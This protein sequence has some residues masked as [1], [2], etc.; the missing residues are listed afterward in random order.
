MMTPEVLT[1]IK[2][3]NTQSFFACENE[4]VQ[5]DDDHS[6]ISVGFSTPTPWKTPREI[7][8]EKLG[9]MIEEMV[10]KV[11]GSQPYDFQFPRP[12]GRFIP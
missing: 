5:V 8:D 7:P 6:M 12:T 10:A 1:A 2:R 4:V 9:E 11:T 3:E